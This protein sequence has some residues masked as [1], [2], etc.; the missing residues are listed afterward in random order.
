MNEKTAGTVMLV[1]SMVIYGTIGV[2]RSYI[3]LP[4]ALLAMLRGLG[5]GALLFLFLRVRRVR[6]SREAIR[7]NLGFLLLSGGM[8]GL[9]WVALFEAYA[10]TTVATATLCYYMAPVLILLLSPLVLGERLTLK[11][12][13][14]ALVSVLGMI[15]VSGVTDGGAAG[16]KEWLGIVL[17]LSAAALYA[18]VIMLNKKL[19]EIGGYER[20]VVQL[21]AAGGVLLPY[22][23]YRGELSG[24]A[25][26]ALTILMTVI[27][28]LV[29]TCLAYSL[30]FSSVRVLDA[31]TLALL[32]YIDPAVAVLLSAL[33]L[34][35][36]MSLSAALGAVLILGSAVVS[37]L[38]PRG[39]RCS[40]GN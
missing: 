5:G 24:P 20:T 33:L 36:P 25:P 15:L 22:V 14:C 30:Y 6:L 12:A 19:Q 39:E 26:D 4:S 38:R 31:Q 18:A 7:Q 9:N 16:E 3:A 27:V 32:S 28:C 11:K 29:H 21:L 40:A 8:I 37:E 13:L 35:E 34:R 10:Y 1:L 2:F 17:G 23:L